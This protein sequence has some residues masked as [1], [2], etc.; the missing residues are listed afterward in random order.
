[1]ATTES[2]KL[3]ELFQEANS[4]IGENKIADA[5]TLLEE[6]IGEEPRFGKAYNH[7]GWIYETKFKDYKRGEEYYKLCL[8]FSPEYSPAYSNYAYLLSALGRY[9][10]LEK[11]LN[12]AV[13]VQGT[14]RP[15]LMN[16]FGIMYEQKGDFAKALEYYKKAIAMTLSDVNLE[17]YGKSLTRVKKKMELLAG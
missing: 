6:I 4:L 2:V 13:T 7:L 15:V 1:M 14:D 3:E 11:H 9:D 17:T 10:D 8:N 16:E 12:F 5:V